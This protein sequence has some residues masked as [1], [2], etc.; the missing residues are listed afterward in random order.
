VQNLQKLDRRLTSKKHKGFF[1]KFLEILINELFSKGKGRGPGPRVRGPAG[2]A[3]STVDQRQR[4]QRVPEHG[5]ALTGVRPP[6][7]PVHQSSPAGAQQRE[8]ST[9]SSIGASPELGRRCGGRATAVQNRRWRL[10]VRGRLERG[11]KRREA[12][13]GAVNSGGGARLLYGSGEHRGGVAGGLT[14]VLMA[15]TP[16][17]MG[18][19]LRGELRE[20]K[21]KA[22]W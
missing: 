16:L 21:M 8:R 6:A 5:G 7:A 22:R 17:K 15:L 4:G 19:G 10:S 14:L 13:R 3:R 9:G 11:E 20:K 1:V 18:E 12:G 2:R